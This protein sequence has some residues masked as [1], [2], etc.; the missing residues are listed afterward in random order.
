MLI[1]KHENST[2]HKVSCKVHTLRLSKQW[3][4]GGGGYVSQSH[5]LGRNKEHPWMHQ[6]DAPLRW[7]ATR[8]LQ[9][10]ENRQWWR[11]NIMEDWAFSKIFKLIIHLK[12]WGYPRPGL[13]SA[14][15]SAGINPVI[16]AFTE[17][18]QTFQAVRVAV[19]WCINFDMFLAFMFFVGIGFI[20]VAWRKSLWLLSATRFKRSEYLPGSEL[21]LAD[22]SSLTYCSS[23]YSFKPYWINKILQLY[24]LNGYQRFCKY[25]Y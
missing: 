21:S 10:T 5:T 15:Q 19:L 3:K 25:K 16:A 18:C 14:L 6:E 9:A 23:N 22:N 2:A 17:T 12:I 11:G 24:K 8:A 20:S 7:T 1:Q 4:E 13:P